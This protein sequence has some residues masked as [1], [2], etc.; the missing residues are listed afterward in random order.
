MSL[1][2]SAR[3]VAWSSNLGIVSARFFS[4]ATNDFAD[5]NKH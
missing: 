4:R 2:T 5:K 3:T 1:N